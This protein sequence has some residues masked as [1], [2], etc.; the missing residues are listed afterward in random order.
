MKTAVDPI[1]AQ[2]DQEPK[3]TIGFHIRGGDKLM[4]D[5]IGCV[6][7]SLPCVSQSR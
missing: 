7:S 4:E 6:P 3:P 5:K 1:L 2:L